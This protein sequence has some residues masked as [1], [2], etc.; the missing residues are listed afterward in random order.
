V[1]SASPRLISCRIETSSPMRSLRLGPNFPLAS[2]SLFYLVR[3]IISDIMAASC[4]TGALASL[5]SLASL[6]CL[7]P[8]PFLLQVYPP[9]P[10]GR[11]RTSAYFKVQIN[12][13]RA[14]CPWLPWLG[15]ALFFTFALAGDGFGSQ[16]IPDRS[17]PTCQR[18]PYL[19]PTSHLPPPSSHILQEGIQ[20]RYH[21]SRLHFR[22]VKVYLLQEI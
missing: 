20:K 10:P 8:G 3:D 13:Q 15:L 17:L 2:P 16:R 12:S 7:A 19:T 18:A 9:W 6:G 11:V 21:H 5:A 4:R 14:G 1:Q 22:G